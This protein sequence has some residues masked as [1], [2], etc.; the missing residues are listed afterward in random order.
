VLLGVAGRPVPVGQQHALESLDL[1]ATDAHA[2]GDLVEALQPALLDL[3]QPAQRLGDGRREVAPGELLRPLEHGQI[4][5]GDVDRL[6]RHPAI[7]AMPQA[8]SY[9]YV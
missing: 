8:Y 4:G 5:V 9:V 6:V 2:D 1:R 7:V 3:D